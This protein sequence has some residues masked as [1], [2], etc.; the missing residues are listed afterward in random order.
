M[1]SQN[2]VNLVNKDIISNKNR[3]SSVK[4]PG[5]NINSNLVS[6]N[7]PSMKKDLQ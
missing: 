5:N 6:S 2:V 3:S 7:S 1:N 4:Q